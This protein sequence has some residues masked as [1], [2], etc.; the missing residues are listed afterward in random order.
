[1]VRPWAPWTLTGLQLLLPELRVRAVAC[2]GERCRPTARGKSARTTHLC[3][4]PAQVC[5][6]V[7]A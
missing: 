2:S 1:M 5:Q 3:W 7:G 6:C 4:H